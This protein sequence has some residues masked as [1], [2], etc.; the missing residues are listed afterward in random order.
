MAE[1]N[2]E[3]HIP[4]ANKLKQNDFLIENQQIYKSTQIV[5]FF[6]TG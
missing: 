4:E 2:H 1:N 6:E 3:E 5:D